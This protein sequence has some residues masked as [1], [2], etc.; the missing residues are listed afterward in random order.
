MHI[1]LSTILTSY[2]IDVA[3]LAVRAEEL[4]FESIWTGDQPILPVVTET[5]IPREWGDIP[6][7]FILLTRAAAVTTTLKLGTAV[8]VVTERHPITLAKQVATLDMYSGGRFLFG[9]GTGSHREEADIFGADFDHRWTQAREAV[10]AMKELWMKEKSEFH[11]RYY[12]FPAVYCY[13]KPVQTPHPSILLGSHVPQVFKRIV[14]YADG[15]VPIGVPA[16]KIADAR[17][18]LN[19]LAEAAGRDPRS[20]DITAFS[21]PADPDV[22]RQYEKA[23]AN[24]VA[25]DFLTANK[26]ESLANLDRIASL[27]F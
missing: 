4:G 7:P 13:P 20:I 12:D 22:I 24:R 21:V 14:D 3:D 27:V 25:L 6:D 8:C 18:Q 5:P 17:K 19:T 16:E 1:G 15:W 9:I 10:G 26:E 23:G 2:S 11:G